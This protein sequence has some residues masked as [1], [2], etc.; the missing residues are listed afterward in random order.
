M[1]QQ[2]QANTFTHVIHHPQGRF[3]IGL[4]SLLLRL[5]VKSKLGGHI[6]ISK[7]RQRFDKLNRQASPALLADVKRENVD[8]N[9]AFAQWL[10]PEGYRPDRVLLYIHGGGFRA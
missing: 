3:A 4:L 9:G 2:I 1:S 8:C 7:L 6:D 5:T 10:S